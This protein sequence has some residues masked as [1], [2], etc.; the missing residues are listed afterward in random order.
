M[1]QLRRLFRYALP[2]L[3]LAA[4]GLPFYIYVP[5]WL[6]EQGGYGYAVIGLVFF[7]ARV[8]DVVTDLPVGT[9]VDR[10]GCRRSLWL[11]GWLLMAASAVLL[12]LAP[13]PWPPILLLLVLISLML[14]WT[15]ITVPWLALAVSLSRNDEQRLAFNSARE[16]MLLFGTLLAMLFPALVAKQ[17]LPYVAAA[18]LLFLL[19]A[20]LNQGSHRPPANARASGFAELLREP[21]VRALALPWFINM[22]ANAIPGTVLVLYLREVLVAEDMIAVVLLSYFLAGLLAVP[23]WYAL[24]KRW[25]SLFCWRLGLLLSAVL[26]SAAA[27]LG[28]GDVAWFVAVSVGT[29]L[30]L[31]ADQAIPSAM[32]TG[33]AR[34]MLSER[35]GA[36]IAAKLF[37]LWSM[38]GK[39]AMGL[40]VGVGYLWLGSQLVPAAASVP[41]DWAIVAAYVV[42]PVVLKLL[43][44]ALLGRPQLRQ[45]SEEVHNA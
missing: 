33:L 36:A 34:K 25:G 38:L 18:L 45:L 11:G 22:L 8:A 30:M 42:A 26:F 2:G 7:V 28:E 17:F 4:L 14:G 3:P 37:A 13:H 23:L 29:G 19:F 32:Q 20:V 9:L 1:T 27:L 16:A 5:L 41:P 35:P 44:F 39:A 10:R 40:A 6:A 24:A 15:L 31:G 21:Q 43:V 12:L